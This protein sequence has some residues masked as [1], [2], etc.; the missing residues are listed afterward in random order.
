MQLRASHFGLFA[1]LASVNG[2]NCDD[3]LA[4]IPGDLRGFICSADDGQRAVGIKLVVT[5]AIGRTQEHTTGADG[6]FVAEDLAV[7]P[8][9]VV[10]QAP[11]IE[12]TREVEI[13]SS[14]ETVFVDS[15]CRA[16][17]PETGAVSGC[18]CEAGTWLEGAQVALATD[19]AL[20]TTTDVDGCFLLSG[21]PVGRQLIVVSQPPLYREIFVE[22]EAG[23]E[24]PIDTPDTCEV[25]PTETGIVDG[26]VCAPD[27][28]TWLAGAT[29]WVELADGSRVETTTDGEGRFHLEGVPAGAQTLHVQ[30]GSFSSERPVQVTTNQTTT[31]AEEECALDATLRIAVVTGTNDNVGS[32]LSSIGIP[33]SSVTTYRGVLRTAWGGELLE[34]YAVLSQYDIVF[35]NCGANGIDDY[36]LLGLRPTIVNDTAMVENLRRF[37]EEGGSVYASDEA[38]D[39]IERAWPDAIDFWGD[40]TDIDAAQIGEQHGPAV[41]VRIVDPGLQA[42]MGVHEFDIHFNYTLWGVIETTAPDTTIYTRGDAPTSEGILE[43]MPLTV[44]FSAGQGRVLYTSF[45]QEPGVDSATE[46][47][48]QL[49]MFEL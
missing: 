3:P 31:V 5:D 29:V 33:A 18:I 28:E 49:L 26:R 11:G 2:C 44:G 27:G 15:N 20:T 34:D 10:V 47:L 1:L 24:V 23:G 30:K 43:D 36:P 42:S 48:L 9:T 32:V 17:V 6:S 37:V 12:R 16:I 46:R 19:P 39:L 40:D 13:E 14:Q 22:V 4:G 38:Y 21:L 8:A 35:I 25:V 7:G 41:P 45:H